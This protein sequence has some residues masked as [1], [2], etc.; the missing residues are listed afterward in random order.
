MCSRSLGVSLMLVA[1]VI[2]GFTTLAA[3]RSANGQSPTGSQERKFVDMLAN[4]PK[5]Y[6]DSGGQPPEGLTAPVLINQH[7][8]DTINP[9][10]GSFAEYWEE[11][12]YGGRQRR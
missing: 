8:F 1:G 2:A 7:Y 3:A 5:Q 6:P 12:S 4:S 11:I 10:L 9:E